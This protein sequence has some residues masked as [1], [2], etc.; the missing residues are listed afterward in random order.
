MLLLWR[1]LDPRL[2]G[3]RGPPRRGV[4]PQV[5]GRGVGIIMITIIIIII[6]IMI[7]TMIIIVMM[8]IA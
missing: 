6:I 8:I 4:A 5:E 3:R 1:P 7:I 2:G